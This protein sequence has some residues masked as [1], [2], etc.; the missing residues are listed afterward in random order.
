MRRIK[1]VKIKKPTLEDFYRSFSERPTN[2]WLGVVALFV[3]ISRWLGH[4]QY[5][6]LGDS[7]NYAL[8][9]DKYDITLH[10][11]HP[12]GY[13]LYILLA[14]LIYGVVGDANKALI[15][16]SILFSVVLVYA[17]F[18]LAK[19]VYNERVAWIAVFL[20]MSS[21]M[22]WFHG[23]VALNYLSD[24]VFAS[25][26]ALFAYRS[27]T[28][29]KS[30]RW[31]TISSVMLAI[32]G[33]FRPT[34]M[35]FL[36]LLWL[37]VVIKKRSW[38]VGLTQVGIVA[39]IT[40]AWLIPAVY[41]SGGL[42]KVWHAVY[43]LIF[44]KS[45]LYSFSVGQWGW[46]AITR[47][48]KLLFNYLLLSLGWSK[49]IVLLFFLSLVIP[50]TEMVKVDYRKLIFW[51]LWL[52]PPTAFYLLV[53]FTI[54]GYLLIALPAVVVLVAKAAEVVIT[55]IAPTVIK[56]IRGQKHFIL[57]ATIT[58]TMALTGANVYNYYRPDQHLVTER[59]IWFSIS[60][61]NQLWATLI[62][63]LRHNFNPQSTIIGVDQPFLAWGL[64][65]FEY[66]FPEYVTYQPVYWG[67]YNPENKVWYKAQDRRVELVDE[68]KF[69]ATDSKLIV[70][71][72]MWSGDNLGSLYIKV[73]LI[74]DQDRLGDIIYYDLT[75]P[76]TRDLLKQKDTIKLFNEQDGS[77]NNQ[78]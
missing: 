15:I 1:L 66:Y 34:L 55:E 40:L 19:T 76:A 17:I 30:N 63:T 69:N 27:L 32:G 72:G 45:A 52:L 77:T 35:V 58:L 11:P 61:L 74:N 49:L 5:L 2:Y 10:Q 7:V 41:L 31:L 57:A 24:A 21:P 8:A 39:G 59:P 13:A 25:L 16:V 29:V 36:A 48:S 70:I 23:Q 43:S 33:G 4:M 68:L 73:P 51:S 53:V 20:M 38:R 42:V 14:K 54:P 56:T 18:Y 64:L 28:E 22:V 44:D 6:Y 67:V 50:R 75:D 12:P 62:P 71:R 47:Y 46:T 37:W 65:H 9:L 60:T 26:F 78:D 3:V